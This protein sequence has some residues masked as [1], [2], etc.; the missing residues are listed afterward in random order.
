[1]AEAAA[2][3]PN[4]VTGD[5]DVAEIGYIYDVMRWRSL[6]EGES[7]LFW[8]V[9]VPST[10]ERYVCEYSEGYADFKKGDSVEII[11][12]TED[13]NNPGYILGLYESEKG[14]VAGT[15]TINLFELEMDDTP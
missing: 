6:W 10:N 8:H 3:T 2:V 4:V 1:M 12:T 5:K 9:V 15:D 13:G 7:R 11:H 14:K